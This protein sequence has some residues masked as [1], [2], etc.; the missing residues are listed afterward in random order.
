M[1]PHWRERKTGVRDAMP[2]KGIGAFLISLQAA[3]FVR[4]NFISSYRIKNPGVTLFPEKHLVHRC[5][6]AASHMNT[7]KFPPGFVGTGERMVH[8]FVLRKCIDRIYPALLWLT[9]VLPFFQKNTS[10]IQS[11]CHP[12]KSALLYWPICKNTPKLSPI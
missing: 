9:P 12:Q 6:L 10:V 11:D 4:P 7:V 3:F 2:E 8:R 5:S 1:I